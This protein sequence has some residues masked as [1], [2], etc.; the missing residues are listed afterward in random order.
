MRLLNHPFP[1]DALT[2]TALALI[3]LFTATAAAAAPYGLVMDDASLREEVSEPV[4]AFVFR[5]VEADSLGSWSRDDM[6]AF[7]DEWA[8][9]S[10]FPLE[11]LESLVR[12]ALPCA[13]G[14]PHWIDAAAQ[15]PPAPIQCG[16]PCAPGDPHWI[17][18]GVPVLLSGE[19]GT[20]KE[21]VARAI[22]A[23]SGRPYS[24]T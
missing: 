23:L 24:L 2:R 1:G 12:E 17:G 20:G 18:A 21:V 6:L 4:F 14:D 3:L 8:R 16:S 9:P 15:K 19:T 22:H 7:A 5:L 11:R 13:P 10:D